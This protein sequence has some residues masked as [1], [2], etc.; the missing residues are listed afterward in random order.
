M[1]Y[2]VPRKSGV[3]VIAR[4]G[5]PYKVTLRREGYQVKPEAEQ[6][7]GKVYVFREGWIMDKD[8]QY[9]GEQILVP[10]DFDWP[11]DAPDWVSIKDLEPA[12]ETKIDCCNCTMWEETDEYGEGGYGLCHDRTSETYLESLEHIPYEVPEDE[13][14]LTHKHYGCPAGVDRG[15]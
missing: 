8:E 2:K 7:D 13:K 4:I 9:P 12:E 10:N 15:R 1:G 14:I 3:G 11:A 6:V 5:Q